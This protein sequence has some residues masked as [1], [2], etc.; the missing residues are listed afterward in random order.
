MS[1]RTQFTKAYGLALRFKSRWQLALKLLVGIWL[2][3]LVISYIDFR[4]LFRIILNA[5]PWYLLAVVVLFYIDRALMAYKWDLL[6]RALNI[7]IPFSQIYQVYT[8]VPLSSTLLPSTI[9]GDLV[10]FA[11]F[12][13]YKVDNKA[14]L[15]SMVV[16]RLIALVAILVLASVSLLAAFFW[17]KGSWSTFAGVKWLLLIGS[18]LTLG[19]IVFAVIFRGWIEKLVLK[20]EPYR[21]IGP[22]MRKL[23]NVYV[24]CYEYQNHPRTIFGVTLWTILEQMVP[25]LENFLLVYAFRI[26]APFWGIAVVI[27]IIVL[28]VRLPISLDGLGIQEGM[29]VA[30]FGLLGVSV[31]QAFLVST[32]SRIIP[33]LAALPWGLHYIMMDRRKILPDDEKPV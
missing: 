17:M 9:G 2:V 18:G 21:F 19:L 26:H 16:E 3:A 5:N 27:P 29:Y 30:L 31:S 11:I 15:A 13:R 14:V 28:A 1:I 12:S 25:I 33:M 24:L 6:L 7:V 8:I 32:I 23:H 20:L 10:R 22:L 4:E